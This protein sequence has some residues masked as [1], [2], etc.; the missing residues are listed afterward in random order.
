M[1]RCCYCRK[2][3]TNRLLR[4]KSAASAAVVVDGPFPKL[5]AYLTLPVS[6]YSLLDSGIIKRISETAFRFQVCHQLGCE[7]YPSITDRDRMTG[8]PST[9]FIA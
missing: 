8:M 4:A 9:L 1:L 7:M 2:S 5:E 6:E 3:N